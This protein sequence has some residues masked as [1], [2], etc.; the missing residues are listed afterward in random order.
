VSWLAANF[1]GLPG[2]AAGS[3]LAVYLDRVLVLRRVARQTGIALRH[4]QDWRTL[5]TQ[6][7]LAASSGAAAWVV[8]DVA[9]AAHSPLLR[10]AAGAAVIALVY[11]PVHL[12]ALLQSATKRIQRENL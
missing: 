12:P 3:V 10:L 1:F 5:A 7:A 11:A 6:L 8:A 4:L 9:L 2:A